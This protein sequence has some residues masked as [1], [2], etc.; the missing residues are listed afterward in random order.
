M[1]RKLDNMPLKQKMLSIL[2]VGIFV[3]AFTALIVVLAVSALYRDMLFQEISYSLSCSAKE[4][5]A[6]LQDMEGLSMML[7]SDDSIQ[8]DLTEIQEAPDSLKASNAVQSLRSSIGGYYQTYSDNI[9]QYITLYAQSSTAY[10]NILRADETPVKIQEEMITLAGLEKGKPL[11]IT[12]YLD[13]YGL[14]LVRSIRKIKNAS[15]DQLGTI[16]LNI[17]VGEL[18]ASATEFESRY[19]ETAYILS[20]DG[21]AIYHTSNLSEDTAEGLIAENVTEYVVY[22][23]ENGR[24]FVVHGSLPDY[25]WD[26]YCMISYDALANRI[27]RIFQVCLAVIALVVLLMTFCSQKLMGQVLI[28]IST[29]TDK[30]KQFQRDNTKMPQAGCDYT[31]REDELGLMHRQFDEMCQTIIRLIQENY[32]NEILKKET[33]LKML[34]DQIN[35][36]FLYNTLGSVKWRA[37][38]IGEEDIVCMVDALSTLLRFSLNS[39]EGH[40]TLGD[41]MEIV[42]SYLTIQKMRYE[43]R[44]TIENRIEPDYYVIRIPKLSVQ[45]LVENAVAYGVE[46]EIDGAEIILDAVVLEGILHIYVKNT[47]SEMEENLMDKL[48]NGERSPHGHGI[49]I[50]NIDSRI[51]MQYGDHFG[52]LL[53]QDDDYATAELVIPAEQECRNVKTDDSGR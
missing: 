25:G 7:L 22:R 26:Y 1:K 45:P 36:H 33:R 49:G 42:S 16:L 11:W 10:T 37:Q 34:E 14:F 3:T 32:V 48:K 18:I 17:D 51:K 28:H 13:T 27:Q 50:A 43:E 41:E 39:D 29:L 12:D 31:N 23:G 8:E 21:E 6:Y 19:E 52:I 24:Y 2:F 38:A 20:K 46:S 15:L 35:P 44:L 30:M 53:Y 5:S 40:F 4:I 9:L 47:G